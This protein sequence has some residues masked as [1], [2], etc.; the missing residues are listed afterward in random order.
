MQRARRPGVITSCSHKK[1][2]KCQTLLFQMRFCWKTPS[3]FEPSSVHCKNTIPYTRMPKVTA[4]ALKQPTW[5]ARHSLQSWFSLCTW[6][7]LSSLLHLFLHFCE[8]KNLK[9]TVICHH[10]QFSSSVLQMKHLLCC[11][12]SLPA[13]WVLPDHMFDSS[14]CC[15]FKAKNWWANF[16]RR[17]SETYNNVSLNSLLVTLCQHPELLYNFDRRELLQGSL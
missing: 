3:K 5:R 9:I 10:L 12:L 17:C 1:V 7:R 4:N 8:L 15:F 2:F 6:C 13:C 16:D 11:F 14:A